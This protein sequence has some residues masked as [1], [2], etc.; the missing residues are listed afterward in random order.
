[1]KYLIPA[2][3]YDSQYGRDDIREMMELLRSKKMESGGGIETELLSDIAHDIGLEHQWVDS[4]GNWKN[5]EDKERAFSLAE[6]EANKYKKGG[7][8]KSSGINW[9]IT[10]K[11]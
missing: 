6:I 7:E 5:K 3:L 9:I 4:N 10:G 1:M 2:F 11:H 8:V